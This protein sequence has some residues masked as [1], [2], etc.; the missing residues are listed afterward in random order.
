M[1]LPWKI[2]LGDSGQIDRGVLLNA[3][4]VTLSV[5]K[6]PCTPVAI[7][8]WI[9]E[10][11]PLTRYVKANNSYIKAYQ[12]D[13]LRFHG[14]VGGVKTTLSS[15]QG[16]T[17]F[18]AADALYMLGRRTLQAAASF[19]TTDMAQIAK[20][21]VDTQN[22]RWPT[23]LR[24]SNRALAALSTLSIDF[25]IDK[26]ALEALRDLAIG[27]PGFECWVDPVDE[28]EDVIG[29]LR[30]EQYRGQTRD[31]VFFEY[32]RG[33]ANI[34]DPVEIEDDVAQHTT[35]QHVIGRDIDG[36]IPRSDEV[37][38]TARAEYNA[39]FD[40]V[41]SYGDLDTQTV[42]D[43]KADQLAQ[44]RARPRRV[45]TFNV[46]P[47]KFEYDPFVDFDVGDYIPTR[48]RGGQFT[49]D[50]EIRSA[51]RVYGFDLTLDDETRIP[52]ID[53]ILLEPDDQGGGIE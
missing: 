48:I 47:D 1:A 45:V 33:K 51:V 4:Q 38:A 36:A 46:H 17:Q 29:D 39:I 5:R 26:P 37:T 8:M 15:G 6:G 13:V 50:D 16:S 24:T 19:V 11:D 27:V 52:R 42:L 43:E 44:W 23:M 20:S 53:K 12:D 14:R 3:R 22:T 49:G 30:I 35:D 9:P 7:G 40:T 34:I 31:N 10:D 2:V 28:T 18:V 32:G 41:D 21:I 25:E